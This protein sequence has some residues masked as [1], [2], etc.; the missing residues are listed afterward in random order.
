MSI[1]GSSQS[2]LKPNTK[3]QDNSVTINYK[4]P[5]SIENYNIVEDDL[6]ISSSSDEEYIAN[7]EEMSSE[8]SIIEEVTNVQNL[9]L[10]NTSREQNL[11][12]DNTINITNATN[13]AR[14]K[15]QNRRRMYP[16]TKT[17]H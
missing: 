10:R 2:A 16:K 6:Y 11:D 5:T 17:K 13:A 7:E 8:S 9:V 12:E 15:R 14:G 4:S 1:P 3:K